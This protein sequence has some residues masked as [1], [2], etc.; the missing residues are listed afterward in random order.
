MDILLIDDDVIGI[1]LTER[2]L[3][4]E[5]FFGKIGSFTSAESALDFLNQAPVADYPRVIFLDLNMPLVDGWD[6]LEALRPL[7]AQLL[8]RCRIYI[9]TSSL[10][11]SDTSRV[12][13]YPLVWGLIHKPIDQ[14]QIQSIQSQ[15]TQDVG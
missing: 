8:G 13:D 1:F 12:K 4:K 6:F 15:L 2:L 3:Q 10:A 11:H 7:E 14:L 9:L 5:S